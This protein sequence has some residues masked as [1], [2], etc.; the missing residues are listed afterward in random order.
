MERRAL[1]V[2]ALGFF[3]MA[4]FVGGFG[5]IAAGWIGA[6]GFLALSAL[7]LTAYAACFL[8]SHLGDSLEFGRR[9]PSEA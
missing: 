6:S 4:G 1:R 8:I 2:L 3:G 7:S 9:Y 5:L